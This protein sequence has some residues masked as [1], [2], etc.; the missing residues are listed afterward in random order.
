MLN[1]NLK[2][3]LRYLDLDISIDTDSEGLAGLRA[4]VDMEDVSV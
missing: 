4:A 2:T 1:P 3:T